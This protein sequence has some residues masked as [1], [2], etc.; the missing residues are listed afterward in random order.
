MMAI[1]KFCDGVS[2]WIRYNRKG[3]ILPFFKM[4]ENWS[5]RLL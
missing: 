2:A 4:S 5:L 3:K 1:N